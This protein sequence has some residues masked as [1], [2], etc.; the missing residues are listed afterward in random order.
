MI[1]IN[2]LF[3]GPARDFAG[4]D[5]ASLELPDHATIAELR[6]ILADRHPGLVGAMAT[7]R[8]AVN[9]EFADDETVLKSGDEVALIP[10]VSG[11]TDAVGLPTDERLLIELVREAIDLD[12][13]RDF[14]TGDVSLGGIVTFEGVTRGETDPEHGALSHL[15]YEAYEAMALEKLGDLAR[16]A[17]ERWSTGRVAI[18]HRLGAVRPGEASVIIAVAC[19]HRAESFA[20]CRW[21]ID[22]LKKDVPIWKKN[23]YQDN[24]TRWVDAKK[25]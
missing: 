3:L 22:T 13:I 20:A 9:Q 6:T 16:E 8:F 23:V 5:D 18:V 17:K 24:F 10:P 14:I 21:L 12:R 2:V 15:L 11:G 7:I 1:E 25:T 19:A 4:V